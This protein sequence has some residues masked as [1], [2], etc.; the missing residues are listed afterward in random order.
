MS[1]TYSYED[2]IILKKKA[3]KNL[4]KTLES[5][6]ARPAPII[7]GDIN[8]IKKTAL[9]S[10]W[11]SQYANYLSFEEK[12]VPTQNI[13]Y[14]RGDIIFVN[15]GFNIGAEL[16]GAHY[17]VV[18]DK[19]S[20]HNSSTVTVIPLSSLKPGKKIHPND[21]YIGN[22]LYEKLHL[23]FK[24]V[25]LH[26]KDE[27]ANNMLI[28]SILK[29]KI[30]TLKHFEKENKEINEIEDAFEKLERIVEKLNQE[31]SGTEQ[32]RNELLSLK[33]GSIAKIK[34]ITTISKIRIYNPQKVSD[35]LN[36]IRFSEDTMIAIND[37]LKESYIL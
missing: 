32:L 35:S 16:G 8:Y 13:S 17:A 2:A 37:K 1:K 7:P 29:E 24:T 28:A 25:L 22:E 27:L 31:I 10:K 30:N 33:S 11:I 3:F 14:S 6:L 34:Q 15:F 9:I 12:F 36:G 18:I 23:K 20:H 4:T 19:I 26:L 21:L 5:F